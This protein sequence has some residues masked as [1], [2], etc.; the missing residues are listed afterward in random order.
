MIDGSSV[1]VKTKDIMK[2]DCSDDK[3]YMFSLNT[4]KIMA[5]WDNN[6]TWME[7]DIK[8]DEVKER[9]YILIWNSIVMGVRRWIRK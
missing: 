2:A 5:I 6:I 4:G 9:V 3:Y 8:K 7:A 1:C